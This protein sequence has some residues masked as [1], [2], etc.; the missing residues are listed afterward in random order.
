MTWQ[1][2]QATDMESRRYGVRRTK[3]CVSFAVL[4]WMFYLFLRQRCHIWQKVFSF[5]LW[6][7]P[8]SLTL[9]EGGQGH[10]QQSSGQSIQ[11]ALILG[12]AF[13]CRGGAWQ[14]L[15]AFIVFPVWKVLE[16][17]RTWACLFN[18]SPSCYEQCS[19][20][21]LFSLICRTIRHCSISF[22]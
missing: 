13:L 9:L 17:T 16:Q 2:P 4:L 18:Q 6:I 21:L 20:S 8:W 15:Q 10:L 12:T 11:L 1:H 22:S 5:S 7:D 19:L 14:L 3:G